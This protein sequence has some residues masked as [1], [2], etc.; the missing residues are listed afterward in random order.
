MN[1]I[2]G[3][4]K[5]AAIIVLYN[6]DN[7][8]IDNINSYKEEVDHL[9]LVDNSEG[10]SFQ[11]TN[12]DKISYMLMEKNLGLCGGLNHGCQKA[13]ADGY[14][15]LITMN[16]DTFCPKGTV[17]KLIEKQKLNQ[18]KMFGANFKYI[19]RNGKDRI[20]SEET[21]YTK[22]DVEVP[23]VITGG[24]VF[25]SAAYIIAGGYDESLFIDNLDRDFCL[26]VKKAGYSIIR[27]GNTFI[28]QEPGQTSTFSLGSKTFHI[29][30]LSP[31]RYFYIFR[32]EKYLRKKYGNEYIDYK[33][34]LFKYLISIIFFE[35]N[36]IEKL[37][38]CIK[39][40]NI[41]KKG[42]W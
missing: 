16:Q 33:V 41:G 29:P 31:M 11:F 24:N 5:S 34:N 6:P 42:V 19:Y 14:E 23:W 26:R 21:P 27:L 22:D 13:I 2:K 28:Y 30:N 35:H 40:N 1:T 8:V 20:F 36:K 32:N 15:I 12:I 4:G 10:L 9:Y 3:K 39:G 37:R 38:S 18:D 17:A 7:E 25:T